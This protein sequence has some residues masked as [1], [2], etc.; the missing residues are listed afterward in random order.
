MVFVV[1][2]VARQN[3]G[4]FVAVEVETVFQKKEDV[5]AFLKDKP[6]SWWETRDVPTNTG[7]RIP[8]EFLVYR[9]I[10]EAELK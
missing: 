10:H 7:E 8:I 6:N 1:F 5:D 4:E 3:E 2:K 9:A